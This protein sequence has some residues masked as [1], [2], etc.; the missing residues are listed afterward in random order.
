MD[1]EEGMNLGEVSGMV[2]KVVKAPGTKL[3]T[4][5]MSKN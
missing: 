5:K 1:I 4:N 3:I 2:I